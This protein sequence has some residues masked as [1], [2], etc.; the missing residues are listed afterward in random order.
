MRAP[1]A[2]G[3]T[4]RG[5]GKYLTS[6]SVC[7]YEEKGKEKDVVQDSSCNTQAAVKICSGLVSIQTIKVFKL[8]GKSVLEI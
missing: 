6:W 1:P 3:M 7:A 4:G 5:S 2:E 8:G